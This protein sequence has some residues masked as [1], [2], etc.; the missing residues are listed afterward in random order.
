MVLGDVDAFMYSDQL[1][2]LYNHKRLHGS[3]WCELSIKIPNQLAR[4]I[5]TGINIALFDQ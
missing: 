3:N 2:D 1:T 5:K 4:T